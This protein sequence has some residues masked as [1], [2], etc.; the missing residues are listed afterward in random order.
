MTYPV[1][2]FRRQGQ[3]H[4]SKGAGSALAY[5]GAYTAETFV[6]KNLAA[7]VDGSIVAAVAGKKIRVLSYSVS[8][9]AGGVSTI[10]FNSKP[11]GAGTAISNLI[12]L[13]ANG[14]AA[15]SDNNGL[16]ETAAG[17]GLTATVVTN[18][19]GLR[20]TYILVD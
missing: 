12:S 8:G 13:A 10:T 9:A 6:F 14:F 5:D 18:T 19:V 16:F 7:G 11:A 2:A 17:E 3:A 4:K 20:I 15:E 1:W